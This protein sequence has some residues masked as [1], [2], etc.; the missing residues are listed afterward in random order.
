M[1][2]KFSSTKDTD[3]NDT[4]RSV[5]PLILLSVLMLGI[6]AGLGYWQGYTKGKKSGVQAVTS[7]ITNL[8]NPL[9]ALSNNPLLPNTVI[10]IV[11]NADS[12][13][14]TVKL[15]NGDQKKVLLNDAT[16]VTKEDKTIKLTDIKKGTAVTI[17]VKTDK[18][19]GTQTANRVIIR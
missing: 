1:K 19:G 10:G 2:V 17:F 6:G 5:A 13:E 18:K 16:V 4:K 9:S 15:A 8:I 7:R 3:R 11:S 12:K 14:M